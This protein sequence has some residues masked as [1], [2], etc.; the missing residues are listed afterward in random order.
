[1][2][3]Y[4]ISR[5]TDTSKDFCFKAEKY[6]SRTYC[7]MCDNRDQLTDW[8]AALTEATARCKSRG[9]EWYL[10]VSSH[11][12]SLPALEIRRPECSGHLGKLSPSRRSWRRRYCVLKD[13][14]VYYYKFI[15][16]FN[17]LGVAH[18][19]GYK[20]DAENHPRRRWSFSLQPPEAGMRVFYF[21]SENETDKKRWVE[22]LIHSI[23][24]WVKTD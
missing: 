14:C 2:T 5:H 20:V 17:A 13:A 16:S 23:Q 1:M 21:S 19:H 22:A 6:G 8:V 15:N 11:N 10:S 7:F 18:L 12:V 4:T 9:K 24:R 3:G